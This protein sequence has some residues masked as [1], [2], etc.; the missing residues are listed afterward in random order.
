MA[1]PQRPPSYNNVSP[2]AGD[3]MDDAHDSYA[4]L[5]IPDY[6]RLLAINV[7][8][9]CGSGM[10]FLAV[11][12][13]IYQRTGSKAALGYVGLAQFFPVLLLSIPVGHLA[14]RV[15]RKRLFVFAQTILAI[16]SASLFMLS[17]L[18]GP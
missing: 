16:G 7:I 1:D 3:G 13:E 15:S 11:E 10:Q 17:Y 8:S 6:R 14:D 9:A 5:R 12:W 2:A 18:E 4:A